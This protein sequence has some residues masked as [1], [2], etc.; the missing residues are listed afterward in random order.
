[1]KPIFKR[2]E[3]NKIKKIIEDGI[4]ISAEDFLSKMDRMK[5]KINQLFDENHSDDQEE[6]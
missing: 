4:S 1:M 5:Q 6:N 2:R 3:T